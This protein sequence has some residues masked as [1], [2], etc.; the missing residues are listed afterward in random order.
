MGSCAW[1]RARRST[2]HPAIVPVS[3]SDA[4]AEA[5]RL[6]ERRPIASFSCVVTREHIQQVIETYC[7]AET[8]KDRDTWLALFAPDATHEDP[9]GAPVRQGYEEVGTVFDTT[10]ADVIIDLH[11]TAPP[12][13]IGHEALAFIECHVGVG[14]ERQLVSPMVNHMV[15]NDEGLIVS[16]RAFY[17]A[18]G[19]IRPDPE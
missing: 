14:A 13:V 6:S 15:F 9:V 4:P 19:S 17:D 12:L 3:R 10:P 5:I 16:V 18:A 8:V 1:G 7:K 2:R 11:P